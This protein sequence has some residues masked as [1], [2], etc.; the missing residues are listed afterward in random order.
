MNPNNCYYPET[1]S[2]QDIIHQEGQPG[3]VRFRSEE[4]TTN[5]SE[6]SV[7]GHGLLID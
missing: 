5:Q 3:I 7:T 1:D 6:L 2:H 4:G